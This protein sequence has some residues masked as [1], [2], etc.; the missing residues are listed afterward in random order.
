MRVPLSTF[1]IQVDGQCKLA[2]SN[3]DPQMQGSSSIILGG[4]FFEEFY[5]AATNQYNLTSEVVQSQ[6]VS[7][8]VQ[9]NAI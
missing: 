2:V 7:L 1:A 6:T 4:M 9:L 3:L 5:G 8:F